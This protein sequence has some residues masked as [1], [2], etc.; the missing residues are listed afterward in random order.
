VY[1]LPCCLPSAKENQILANPELEY[2]QEQIKKLGHS[3]ALQETICIIKRDLANRQTQLLRK[4]L[5]KWVEKYRESTV[6]SHGKTVRE[7]SQ[8]TWVS[9]YWGTSYQKEPDLRK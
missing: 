7:T 5:V 6:L 2:Q 8:K 3:E 1:G 4:A 9:I